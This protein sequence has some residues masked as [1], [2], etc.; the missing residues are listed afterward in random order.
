M[1]SLLALV[2]CL[3]VASA[4]IC[5]VPAQWEGSVGFLTGIIHNG[6]IQISKVTQSI[7]FIFT[8][9]KYYLNEQHVVFLVLVNL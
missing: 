5:C 2:S 4:S 9:Y 3:A 7:S 6:K 8:S 1:Y